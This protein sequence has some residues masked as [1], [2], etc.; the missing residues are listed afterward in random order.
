M[1]LDP[2]AVLKAI[3]IIDRRG[4]LAAEDNLIVARFILEHTDTPERAFH[5]FEQAVQRAP[6]DGQLVPAII[7]GLRAEGLDDWAMQL[8]QGQG[9]DDK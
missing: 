4:W 7:Q 5:Y 9:R 2:V 1:V 8:A 6:R 3:D